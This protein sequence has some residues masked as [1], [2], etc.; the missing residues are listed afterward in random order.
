MKKQLAVA[1]LALTAVFAGNAQAATYT[2][3]GSGGNLGASA[4]F[5][6]ASGPAMTATAGA[7]V[8]ILN[9]IP[10]TLVQGANGL[11][12]TRVLDSNPTQI[13]G[14]PLLTSEYI[15]FNFAWAVKL[16]SFDLLG[17]DNNDNYDISVNGGS[18]MNGLAALTSN[19]VGV[20]N[21][22]SFTLRASGTFGQDGLLGNDEFSAKA[23]NVAEVV[24][25]V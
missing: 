1:A 19:L 12:V 3:S 13:D 5:T 11:G 8:P 14:A 16:L 10:A 20:N 23:V 21:V 7:S 15:T 2:L 4:G 22:T 9:G 18:F 17:V 6:A 24:W 25:F